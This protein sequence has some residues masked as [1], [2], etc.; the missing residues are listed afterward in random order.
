MKQIY[1]IWGVVCIIIGMLCIMTACET[2]KETVQQPTVMTERV[3]TEN[4]ITENIITENVITWDDI[5]TWD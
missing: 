5:T 2:K 1:K 3:L 4:V